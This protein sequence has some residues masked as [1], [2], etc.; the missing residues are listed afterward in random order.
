MP[1]RLWRISLHW[2][3]LTDAFRR[4][5]LTV[6]KG[7]PTRRVENHLR[8]LYRGVQI[9]GINPRHQVRPVSVL[10]PTN[11]QGYQV[12]ARQPRSP[13]GRGDAVR[14]CLCDNTAHQAGDFDCHKWKQTSRKCRGWVWD[15]HQ[16]F[17]DGGWC[18]VL[19]SEAR[20]EGHFGREG[21]FGY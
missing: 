10:V 13:E 2:P 5:I 4:R 17:Y 12:H 3:L 20:W 21:W 6:G 19:L 7:I 16:E 9:R 1:Y 15:H 8:A 11:A 14:Q 18:A